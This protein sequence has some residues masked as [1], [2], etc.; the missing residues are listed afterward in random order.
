MDGGGEVWAIRR[1]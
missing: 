1:E